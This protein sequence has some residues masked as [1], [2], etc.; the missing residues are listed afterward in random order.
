EQV[1][2]VLLEL[3][4]E[5]GS[6]AQSASVVFPEHTPAAMPRL[7]ALERVHSLAQVNPH[8]PIAWPHWPKGLWPKIVAATKKVVRRMLSWYINPIVEQQNR[9]NAAV[10]QSLDMLW[11]EMSRLQA[12]LLQEIEGPE[13]EDE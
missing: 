4:R 13:A 9:Y 3:K 2:S 10:A 7:A 12:R 1:A 8:L 11:W 5:V 6:Q